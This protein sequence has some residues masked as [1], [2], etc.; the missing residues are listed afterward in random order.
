MTTK[1]QDTFQD[2]VFTQT[3]HRVDCIVFVVAFVIVVGVLVSRL[4]LMRFD[5]DC[6]HRFADNDNGKAQT[7]C[8][9]SLAHP[10]TDC[11]K[12]HRL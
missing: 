5:G 11:A 3:S 10:R 4:C 7:G 8:L 6:E 9:A 2:E 12:I 1:G